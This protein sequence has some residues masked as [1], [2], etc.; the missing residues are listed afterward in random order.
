MDTTKS[1]LTKEIETAETAVKNSLSTAEEEV[2]GK[3]DS[4]VG[5]AE[6]KILDRLKAAQD[7]IAGHFFDGDLQE[8]SGNSE[9]TTNEGGDQTTGTTGT[10]KIR[11]I[12]RL[13]QWLSQSQSKWPVKIY[14]ELYRKKLIDDL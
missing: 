4:T 10:G 9:Q 5:E 6:T 7:H 2:K 14:T 8:S 12:A 1:N 3:V 11:E 13:P